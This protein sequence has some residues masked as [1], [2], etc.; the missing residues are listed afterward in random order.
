MGNDPFTLWMRVAQGGDGADDHRVDER[1]QSATMPSLAACRVFTAEWAM[2]ADPMPASLLKAARRKPWT[3]T[4]GT[5][6]RW[7]W[8]GTH[9]R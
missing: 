4:P 1:F 2:A 7:P 6:P 5:H 9:P 3:S 8:D